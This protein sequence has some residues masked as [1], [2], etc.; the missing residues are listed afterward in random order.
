ML[1]RYVAYEN[2][3]RR[4][5]TMEASSENE[6][7]DAISQAGW[8]LISV[9][10]IVKARPSGTVRFARAGGVQ[11]GFFFKQLASVVKMG[12]PL[13][14]A[15]SIQANAAT[16]TW[17]KILLSLE[18]Q[19]RG[20]M[21]LADA[22]EAYPQVFKPV[23]IEI[24]RAGEQSGTADTSLSRCARYVDNEISIKKKIKSATMYPVVVLVLALGGGGFLV[25]KILPKITEMLVG[26]NV[27]LPGPT[28]FLI[29]MTDFLLKYGIHVVAGVI[30]GIIAI[31]AAKRTRAGRM[32]MDR[33]SLYIPGVKGIARASAIT[34]FLR[35]LAETLEIGIPLQGAL[36]LATRAVGNGVLE[37]DV[38]LMIPKAVSGAGLAP[39]LEQSKIFPPL[40]PQVVRL[41]EETGSVPTVLENLADYYDGETDSAVKAATSLIEP[42][43]VIAVAGIVGFLAVAIIMPMYT[44]LGTIGGQ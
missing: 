22:M 39:T 3:R 25:T 40:V 26:M 11:L 21:S 8:F 10:Q 17:R 44:M 13:T 34:R 36:E 7:V 4:V 31:I 35:V 33:I 32:V 23:F 2:S 19:V 14:R 24:I 42:A 16:G 18:S 15:L 29:N 28:K 38:S 43:M 9:N 1:Y 20:G 37:K 6:V 30:L 27:P 5:G 41:G 12:L